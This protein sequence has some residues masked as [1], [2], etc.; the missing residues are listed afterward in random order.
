MA[1]NKVVYELSLKDMLTGKLKEADSQAKVL[2]STMG[3]LKTKLGMVAGALG[4]SFAAFKGFELVHEGIESL[5]QLHQAE[6]QVKAGLESTGY[7]AG[8]TGEELETMAQK[9]SST[10]KYTRAELTGMQSIL[11]T[12][13]SVMKD[14]FPEATNIIMDMSTRLGQDLKSSAI[15][16]GKAL[17]DPEKGITALRRVGVNFNDTQTET[18]KRLAETGQMAKAQGM[19]LSELATEF[20]GSAKDAFDADPL[21]RY[22]KMMGSMKMAM[23]EAGMAALEELQP[24]LIKL[25][26]GVKTVATWVKESVHWL[27]ENKEI[28]KAAGVAVGGLAVAMGYYYIK[29]KA[30]AIWQGITNTATAT[31]TFLQIALGNAYNV[32]TRSTGLLAAAQW[33]LNAAWEANPVGI[34]I[35]GLAA[36]AAGI[37]YAWQKSVTFRAVVLGLWEV[38]KTVG[39]LIKDYFV[40]IYHMIHGAASLNVEE[41]RKG[42][43]QTASVFLEGGKKV[44]VAFKTGY[45]TEMAKAAKDSAIKP[46]EKVAKVPKVITPQSNEGATKDISPKGATGQKVTTINVSIGNLINDFKVQTTN[47]T[48]GAGKIKELV[49]QALMSAVN[50]SQV[51]AGS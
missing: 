25:A 39:T 34:V 3:G 6:A 2:E 46:G 9:F 18:I 13:P 29:V 40:G 41:M 32:S 33:A 24:A 21:A 5:E 48:E 45:D 30:V 16:V 26:S 43:N 11:L 23:G 19:I 51:V 15:Q 35:V 37:Y 47:I 27:K 8:L 14:K 42:F 4:V 10:S 49:A 12:F 36:L 20:G 31:G 17:Q 28:V 50:D 22:N 7:A 38:T 44:A 1:D